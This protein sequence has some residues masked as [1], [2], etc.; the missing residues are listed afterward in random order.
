[1]LRL[2]ELR[3]KFDKY[4]IMN[5]NDIITEKPSIT[6]RVRS[7][8]QQRLGMA[9]QKKIQRNLKKIVN[10]TSRKIISKWNKFLGEYIANDASIKNDTTKQL[11]LF[12]FF[13]NKVFS[14]DITKHKPSF[15]PSSMDHDDYIKEL[16][17]QSLRKK[18]L[19]TIDDEDENNDEDESSEEDDEFYS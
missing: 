8:F 14:V 2:E 4:I 12:K 17:E 10:K 5:L 7:S 1:M 15:N 3:L 9:K 16:V 11:K 6:S 19:K 13:I 18:Y